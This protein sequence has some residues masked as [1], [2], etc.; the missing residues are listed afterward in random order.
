MQSFYYP[1]YPLLASYTKSHN[2]IQCH[3]SI[4]DYGCI[5]SIQDIVFIAHNS[6]LHTT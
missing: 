5:D 1:N 3:T 2:Q 4:S 6:T